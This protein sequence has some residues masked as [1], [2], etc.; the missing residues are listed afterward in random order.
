MLVEI[1]GVEGRL[2][3]GDHCS[4]EARTG[5]KVVCEVVGFSETS[6]LV[7]PFG[8][9]EGIGLGCNV[10]IGTSE[11]IIY[12]DAGWLGRV[13]DAFGRPLD[14]KGPLPIGPAR[15]TI[16]NNP[17][18]AHKRTRVGGKVD[19]G[20]RVMN[21]FFDRLQRSAHGYF[22]RIRYRQPYWPMTT[23]YLYSETWWDR[24]PREG[25]AWLTF[26]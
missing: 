7:M 2:S 22:L 24:L 20:V 25:H 6:A 8:T 18:P 17:P 12:P 16:Q 21:A 9:L 15:Y 10:E 13:I 14:D 5:R 11:P 3:I 19:L 1:N 23:S 4:I 26:L